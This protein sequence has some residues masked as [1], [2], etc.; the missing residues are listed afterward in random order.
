MTPV[1]SSEGRIALSGFLRT[2]TLLAF[3][4]DGTLAPIVDDPAQARMAAGTHELLTVVARRNP[5]IILSGRSRGDL[6]RFLSGVPVL[7]VIGNHGAE[8]YGLP[9]RRSIRQL[10]QWRQQLQDAFGELPGVRIEDKHHSLSIHYRACENAEAALHQ[11]RQFCETL[12]GARLI[13]GKS[14][15]NLMP[16]DAPDKGSAL[17]QA[18]ERLGCPR[19]IFVGDDDTDEDVFRLT[20]PERLFGIRVGAHDHSQAEYLLETQTQIDALLRQLSSL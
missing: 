4:Y 11:I 10:V 13:G 5:T 20:M 9:P 1:L 2:N 14:V 12:D 3:D 19:A 8:A 18:L 15:L 16:A 17:L 6:L 7:E